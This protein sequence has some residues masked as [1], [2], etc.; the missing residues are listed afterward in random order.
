MSLFTDLQASI[1]LAKKI[2]EQRATIQA[3][4][5]ELELTKAQLAFAN[6]RWLK[7]RKKEQQFNRVPYECI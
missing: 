3:L 7:E 5:D 4:R 1:P 2:K 6:A